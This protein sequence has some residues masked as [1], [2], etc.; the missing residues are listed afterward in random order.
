MTKTEKLLNAFTNGE[1]LSSKQIASRFG[2]KNPT[3][4][5]SALRMAGYPIYFNERKT[6]VSSYRLGTA[7][8]AVVAA[9]Y[10]ALA[11]G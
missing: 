5:V 6:R 2:I 9:G 7:S 4:A 1:E 10:R 11:N 8:R 3:A